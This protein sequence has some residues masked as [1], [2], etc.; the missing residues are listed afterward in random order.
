MWNIT[1]KKVI[2]DGLPDEFLSGTSGFN[3][4]LN[5]IKNTIK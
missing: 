2:P 5:K 1:D 4:R 3:L